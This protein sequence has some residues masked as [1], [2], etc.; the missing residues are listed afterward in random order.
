M[1]TTK[2]IEEDVKDVQ[3]DNKQTKMLNLTMT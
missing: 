3:M 2:D 1:K